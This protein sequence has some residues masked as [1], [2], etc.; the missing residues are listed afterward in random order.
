M[1]LPKTRCPYCHETVVSGKDEQFGCPKCRAWHHLACWEEHS[2]CS[3]C[4][5]RLNKKQTFD[6]LA[7]SKYLGENLKHKA[8]FD[9]NS[10]SWIINGAKFPL[11]RADPI[12][13]GIATAIDRIKNDQEFEEIY[14]LAQTNSQG[15]LLL[16][17]GKVYRTL[18]ETLYGTECRAQTCDWDF[19][20]Q[21]LIKKA[22]VP[23]KWD[24]EVK[25]A[26]W[27]TIKKVAPYVVTQSPGCYRFYK[28][29]FADITH[30]RVHRMDL[31]QINKVYAIKYPSFWRR[32]L[33]IDDY[34]RAVPFNIQAFAFDPLNERIFGS[35]EAHIGLLSREIKL[36]NLKAMKRYI[37]KQGYA[38][39]ARGKKQEIFSIPDALKKKASEIDFT[40]ENWPLESKEDNS[41]ELPMDISWI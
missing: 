21:K 37:D 7:K 32:K 11:K 31:M 9:Q 8:F 28:K 12:T 29:Y 35:D 34:F 30:E 19:L 17:G 14:H 33:S 38:T 22:N 2:G 13:E 39:S 16:V 27:G 3:S 10:Q 24:V 4:N 6:K 25:D 20:T 18:I 23:R 1:I 40:F 15:Q 26:Y 41:S 36:N 5:F